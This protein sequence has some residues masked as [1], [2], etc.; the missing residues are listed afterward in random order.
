MIRWA[1][2]RSHWLLGITAGVV[3]SVMGVTGALM[4]FGDEIMM[5]LSHGIVDVPVRVA[6]VMTPDGLL[7]R[8]IAQK[9]DATPIKITLFPKP[10]T[11]ARLVYRTR[12]VEGMASDDDNADGTYLDPYTGQVLGKAVGEAFFDDVLLLH[13]YLLLP[14]NRTGFGRPITTVAA[15][16]LIYIALSGLYLRWPRRVLDWR[17]WLKP[18]LNRRGGKVFGVAGTAVFMF[19]ALMLPFSCITGY[20]L[21]LSR[22]RRKSATRQMR[23]AIPCPPRAA[24]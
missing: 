4:A 6:P 7:A 20:L 24:P 5:S 22:R 23:P 16:C 10:G 13:R 11:S 3:L 17:A 14:H 1:I 2:Y 21:Y 19:A 12:S 18:D 9:P 15:F 8:F